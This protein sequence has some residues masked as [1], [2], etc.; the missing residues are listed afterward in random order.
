MYVAGETKRRQP[1][2][3]NFLSFLFLLAIFQY[4][5][6]G[7]NFA[8]TKMIRGDIPSFHIPPPKLLGP[9]AQRPKNNVVCM[10]A[11]QAEQRS[12]QLH[13]RTWIFE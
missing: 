3:S 10:F 4:N 12:E 13:A 6:D 9:L 2:K 8:Y 11:P 1:E 5:Q 7:F